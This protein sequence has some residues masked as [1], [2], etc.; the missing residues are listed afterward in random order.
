MS[1]STLIKDIK[2][3]SINT[4]VLSSQVTTHVE[5]SQTQQTDEDVTVQE[6]LSEI[7]KETRSD[8]TQ[9][10]NQYMHTDALS[11]QL[12]QQQLLQQQL[13]QQQIQQQQTQN[14][15]QQYDTFF[16]NLVSNAKHIVTRD[17]NLLVL[18]IVLFLSFQYVDVLKVLKIDNLSV[19]ERYPIL[20]NVVISAIFGLTLVVIKP[21]M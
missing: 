7:E 9:H 16:N 5:P 17:N 1:K 14:T 12:L 21:L 3:P 20:V 8:T 19:F 11:N 18:A 10:N 2:K 6:V 13:L 4:P 15:N